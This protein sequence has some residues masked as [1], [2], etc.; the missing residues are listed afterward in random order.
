MLRHL[1]HECWTAGA[2]GLATA[3]DDTLTVWASN[4]G[5][6]VVSTDREFGQRRMRNAIGHHI[7]L[8]CD[9]WEA[10]N[11]LRSHVDEVVTRLRA[12]SDLTI[13]VSRD[14]V[15]DSSQWR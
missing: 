7:W 6:A 2:V 1:R 12:R 10:G 14:A 15:I 4:H 9:D 3:S 11:V 8:Q 13:R 5:A